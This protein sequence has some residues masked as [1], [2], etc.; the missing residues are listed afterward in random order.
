MNIEELEKLANEGN[1]DAMQKLVNCYYNG[2]GVEK[3]NRKSEEWFDKAALHGAYGPV[4][5]KN[6]EDRLRQEAKDN[7]KSLLNGD[8]CDSVFD[9]LEFVEKDECMYQ[10]F[11]LPFNKKEDGEMMV[12]CGEDEEVTDVQ[13]KAYERYAA[14]LDNYMKNMPQALLAYYKDNYVDST[15]YN[16]IYDALKIENVTETSLCNALNIKCLYID[17]DGNFGWLAEIASKAH[18]VTIILS[19]DTIKVHKGWALNSVRHG[20]I[21]DKVLGDLYYKD[22]Y[23]IKHEQFNIEDLEHY[24]YELKFEEGIDEE[25]TPVQRKNYLDYKKNEAKYRDMIPDALLE[26]YKS[27]Y[28][29]IEECWTWDGDEVPTEY[30][31]EHI[32][33]DSVLDLID[34][35]YMVFRS[36]E[37]DPLYGWVTKTEWGSHCNMDVSTGLSIMF[38]DEGVE[39]GSDEDLWF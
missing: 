32:S 18:A 5:Q 39:V 17:R 19:E 11:S 35:R 14:G 20:H 10:S 6:A 36:D 1:V 26:D 13:Q 21:T 37:E 29:F 34:F 2:E 3:D 30:D 15:W 25:I 27:S 12:Q 23:W 33:K 24:W 4:A 22:D 31:L 28:D 16:Y 38:S 9:E 8:C 7:Q